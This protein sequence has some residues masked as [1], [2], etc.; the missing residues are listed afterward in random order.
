MPRSEQDILDDCQAAI[1][2]QFRRP[3]L[4][5]AALTHTS[6][7]N[8]RLASNERLEFL[9]DSVLGLVTCAL[10]FERFPTYHEG[11]MTK[12]KSIVVSRKTCAAFS[13]QLGLGDFLF[14]GKDL[15]SEIP[16][17]MHADV[18]ESL[19]AAIF[20][21]G[22]WETAREFV[23]DFVDPEIER[24]VANSNEHNA[25]SLL[26]QVAQKEYGGIPRYEVRDEQGPDH[27][28][29][30]KIEVVING[31]A[32]EPAWGKNKKDAELRAAL[33]ALAVIEGTDVPYPSA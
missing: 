17:N 16:P 13:R 5:R 30:Y 4:L 12:I 32:F 7:A 33:N 10:L 11:D 26:Q 27:N 24:A 14:T 6:G 31:Y 29:C 22:G 15:R 18:F 25:K 3:E 28:K 21:D 1:G 20:L 9:G 8:T 2:Y 19:V 23:L